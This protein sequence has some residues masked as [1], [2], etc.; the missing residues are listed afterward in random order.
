MVESQVSRATLHE[1]LEQ[2]ATPNVA[3]VHARIAAHHISFHCWALAC[4][5]AGLPDD[6]AAWQALD[7]L[8]LLPGDEV[9]HP[10]A[11]F[12]TKFDEIHV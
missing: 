12:A 9:Q 8:P 4:G 1:I 7:A 6:E 3:L 5:S 10:A 11:T 2:P